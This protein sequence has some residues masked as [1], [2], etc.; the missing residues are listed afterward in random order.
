ME[1]D[2]DEFSR[3]FNQALYTFNLIDSDINN[4]GYS[5]A[6]FKA[7]Q[8]AEMAIKSVLK[9]V[10]RNAYGHGLLKLYDELSVILTR[11]NDVRNAVSYLD[12]L[13]IAPGYPDAFTEG[14]PWEHFTENDAN[15]A[16]NS[17][18]III[19]Y[20]KTEMVQCL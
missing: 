10:G 1:L 8:C 17:A 4:N 7:Q 12:K 20:V 2:C 18:Q 9:A 19:S 5:W 6:C 15:M 13:Y 14:S 11:K 3:W 16:K